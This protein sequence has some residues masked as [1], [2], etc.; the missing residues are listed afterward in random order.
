MAYETLQSLR[1]LGG[2]ASETIPEGRF[3]VASQSGIH[4]DLPNVALAGSGAVNVWV[5][6]VPPDN[7]DR[8]TPAGLF[9]ARDYSTINPRNA[10]GF[11]GQSFIQT[12]TFYN[13]GPSVLDNP[14]ATS[15]WKL[16][17]HRG[18]AYTVPISWFVDHPSLRVPF[19]RIRCA[20]GGSGAVAASNEAAIGE[21][22]EYN[23]ARDE[24]TFTLYLNQ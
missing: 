9:T 16:Q 14:T 19:T 5:A 21:I 6:L 8:P 10:T 22:L 11:D 23:T 1:V 4:E 13:I 18:G 17:L 20:G 24:I 3:V 15:G 2:V 12:Q 7:F